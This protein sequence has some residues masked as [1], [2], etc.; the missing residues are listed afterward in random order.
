MRWV[1]LA[2][3]LMLAA[4]A[5]AGAVQLRQ[6]AATTPSTVV[7]A[8]LAAGAVGTTMIPSSP[9]SA[10]SATTT[11]VSLSA[12]LNL[13]VLKVVP[14]TQTWRVEVDIQGASGVGTLES[15]SILLYTGSGL[16]D[17]QDSVSSGNVVTSRSDPVTL[18][19]GGPDLQ[20]LVGAGVCSG[21]SATMRI[22]FYPT[23]RATAP[24]FQYSYSLST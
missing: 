17:L 1:A 11:G 3:A 23:D 9:N 24:D 12:I 19:A 5:A 7:P 8:T 16:P 21:C 20:V 14:G 4:I 13:Q 2:A 18:S 15:L 22:L 6:D 10:T